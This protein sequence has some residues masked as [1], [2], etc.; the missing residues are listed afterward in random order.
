VP[1]L[2]DFNSIG[3]GRLRHYFE[4]FYR[5]AASY[6]KIKRSEDEKEGGVSLKK[7]EALA[8]A[9]NQWKENREAKVKASLPE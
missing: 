6:L 2:L 8:A 9:V 4:I 3:D 1:Q 5:T 7:L